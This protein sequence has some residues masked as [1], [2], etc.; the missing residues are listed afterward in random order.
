M[1]DFLELPE[2]ASLQNYPKLVPNIKA[3]SIC[4]IGEVEPNLC[5][6]HIDKTFNT[7]LAG[8]NHFQI[9]YFNLNIVKFIL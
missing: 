2:K 6:L 1:D 3:Q 5:Q 9:F 4:E 8:M 7:S